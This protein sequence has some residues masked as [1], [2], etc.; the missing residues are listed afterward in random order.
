MT[1]AKRIDKNSAILA[2]NRVVSYLK[3]RMAA[4]YKEFITVKHHGAKAAGL[5]DYKQ[6]TNTL[7]RM[8][9]KGM[10]VKVGFGK[11][12]LGSV[13]PREL[14]EIKVNP[15]ISDKKVEE[16]AEKIA[17]E[18][19]K[20]ETLKKIALEKADELESKANELS[21][22]IVEKTFK[23]QVAKPEINPHLLN[24][25]EFAEKIN[26]PLNIAMAL[27][28]INQKEYECAILFIQRHLNKR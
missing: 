21:E 17:M 3:A 1:R 6:I 22:Q 13:P 12:M 26:A 11:Y 27:T 19:V 25:L 18:T 8:A 23:K 5:K 15:N 9:V 20:K 2:E 14:G 28:A 24:A 4:G 16:L 10:L 7:S